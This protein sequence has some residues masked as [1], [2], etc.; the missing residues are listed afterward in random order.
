MQWRADDS[1]PRHV[2]GTAAV[3]N[4]RSEDMGFFETIDPAA[5][6]NET[7]A[8]SDVF[9]YLNHDPQRGILARAKNGRGSLQLSV[10]GDGLHYA[11]DAPRTALGDELLE[12]LHRGDITAS[13]FAFTVEQ[14]EWRNV[15]GK[16]QRTILKID[17]LYDVS[18]VFTPAYTATSVAQRKADEMANANADVLKH[19]ELIEKEVEKIF[20]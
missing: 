19:L 18:P 7:I 10:D 14:D 11:F 2:E 17:R 1:N 13:S 15:N 20:S 16:P 9:A 12:Y 8:R 4:S 3:F 5:I 6:D